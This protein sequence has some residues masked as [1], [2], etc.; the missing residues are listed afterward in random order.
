MVVWG[1]YFLFGREDILYCSSGGGMGLFFIKGVGKG[2]VL[3]IRVEC[4]KCIFR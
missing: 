3:F 4:F 2:V 1:F